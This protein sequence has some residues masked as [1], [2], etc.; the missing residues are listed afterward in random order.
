MSHCEFVETPKENGSS[1]PSYTHT[2]AVGR[3]ENQRGQALTWR[4]WSAPLAGIGLTKL[5]KS[6]SANTPLPPSRFPRPYLLWCN[7]KKWSQTRASK[8]KKLFHFLGHHKV[9]ANLKIGASLFFFSLWF[10]YWLITLFLDEFWIVSISTLVSILFL[11]SFDN[12]IISIKSNEASRNIMILQGDDF[13]VCTL[14]LVN[15]IYMHITIIP[16][17]NALVEESN[18]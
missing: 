6:S 12:L 14:L 17:D 5:P 2:R 9:F 7:D 16:C 11:T 4:A 13:S 3:S 8:S 1:P 18:M 10:V 15:S